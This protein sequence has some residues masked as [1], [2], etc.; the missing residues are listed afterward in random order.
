MIRIF[1]KMNEV[2]GTAAERL[3]LPFDLRQRSRFTATLEDGSPVAISLP[4]GTQLR[5]GDMLRAETNALIEIRA[6]LESVSTAHAQTPIALARACFHL[7]NRHTRIQIGPN[8]V[9]YLHDHVLDEMVLGF[10]LAIVHELTPF[11]PESGAYSAGH[12]AHHGH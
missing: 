2:N 6:A 11:E 4:R 12:V 10:G 3:T 9:R 8:W 7:G 1:E 5:D